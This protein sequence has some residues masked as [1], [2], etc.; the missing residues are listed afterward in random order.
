PLM[1]LHGFGGDKD[2]F[3]RVARYLTPHYRVI[4]PD[5]I[6][7]GESTHLA[8][9]DYTTDAQAARLH[10]LVQALGVTQLH[11]GGNSMGGHI[12]MA[13]AAKYPDMA[14]SLW[15][16]NPGG[17]WSSELS[18]MRQMVE[19]T[20]ENP[21]LARSEEEFVEIFDF[22]MSE[23]PFVPRPVLN[24]MAQERIRNYELERVIFKQISNDPIEERVRGLETPAMVVWGDQDRVLH[25]S[26][27]NILKALMPRAQVHIMPGIGHVPML[28]RPEQTAQDYLKYRQSL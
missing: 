14:Q 16:L 6:G 3:T 7:F 2:N 13:F 25:M 17:V 5:H 11:L 18:E 1:L 10:A 12:A 24:V 19:K 26:G 15:L 4:I 20:G 27:A 23:A 22:V 9:A 21:L 8:D 28:E